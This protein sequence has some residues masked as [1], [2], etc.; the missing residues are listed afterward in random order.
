M[1]F[2]NDQGHLILF[3]AGIFIGA[4]L[5]EDPR[6]TEAYTIVGEARQ[7]TINACTTVS[8]LSEVYAALTWVIANPQHQPSEAAEAV[9][10][11]FE[12]PSLIHVLRDGIDVSLKMLEL[13]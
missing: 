9:R 12:P 11:L 5:K 2:M 6:H 13:S 3:D 10:L 1:P 7:G 4:L 8:I